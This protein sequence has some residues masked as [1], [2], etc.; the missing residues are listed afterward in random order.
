MIK[1]YKLLAVLAMSIA[2]VSCDSSTDNKTDNENKI[3]KTEAMKTKLNG[4]WYWF[5]SSGGFAGNTVT[6]ADTKTNVNILFEKGDSKFTMWKN[7]EKVDTGNYTLIW[8]KS[9]FFH[10]SCWILDIY[11]SPSNVFYDM[12]NAHQ[13][14]EISNDTLTVIPP[15]ADIYV[16]R[17][18]KFTNTIED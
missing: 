7:G 8:G 6:P 1:V 5:E 4:E 11:P 14:I 2:I 18:R 3:D 17:L 13:Q 10:D 12:M 15:G 9:V 16:S